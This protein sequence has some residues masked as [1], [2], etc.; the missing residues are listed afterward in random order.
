[1]S[2]RHI[3]IPL[4]AV[5]CLILAGCQSAYYKTMR[6]FGKEKRDILVQRIKES[7]KDQERSEGK[8]ENDDGIL[9]GTYRVSGWIA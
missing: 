5:L 4:L 2:C 9:S 7:K 8:V 3:S 1:M 6:T